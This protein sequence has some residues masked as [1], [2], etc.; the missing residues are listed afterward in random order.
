MNEETKS[1]VVPGSMY[2]WVFNERVTG[3]LGDHVIHSGPMAAHITLKLKSEHEHYY[4]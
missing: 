1:D 4:Q 2:C 3:I